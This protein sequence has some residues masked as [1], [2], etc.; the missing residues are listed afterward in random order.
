MKWGRPPMTKL[1]WGRE[2]SEYL[3]HTDL[4]DA[5]QSILDTGDDF[6]TGE[7][8]MCEYTTK[9]PADSRERRGHQEFE[10]VLEDLLEALNDDEDFCYEGFEVEVT[11]VPNELAIALRDAVTAIVRWYPC[12]ACT[13][14]GRRVIVD[15]RA[16][17]E[18]HAP[19]WLETVNGRI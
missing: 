8:V 6:T 17:V 1:L 14:T 16:W 12:N 9:Q 15:V 5:V 13:P 19:H 11:A 4:D 2:H 7:L 18:T 3:V 10:K